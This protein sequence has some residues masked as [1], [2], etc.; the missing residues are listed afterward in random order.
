MLFRVLHSA[1]QLS[2]DSWAKTARLTLSFSVILNTAVSSLLLSRT[3]QLSFSPTTPMSSHGRVLSL[4]IAMLLSCCGLAVVCCVTG[5]THGM[6][7]LAFMAAEVRCGHRCLLWSYSSVFSRKPEGPCQFL[8]TQIDGYLVFHV[9]KHIL[10]SS[11]LCW[12][13]IL[14]GKVCYFM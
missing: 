9:N 3:F 13:L 10:N 2:T 14:K 5:Y 11:R 1:M 4:L 8:F 12:M 7:T 6:H